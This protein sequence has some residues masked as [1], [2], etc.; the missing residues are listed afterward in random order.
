M[1]YM[2]AVD[3]T[4]SHRFRYGITPRDLPYH[5]S[6]D[7]DEHARDF[8]LQRGILKTSMPCPG[9]TAN[10]SLVAC[11]ASRD[12][13]TTYQY[14]RHRPR[15]ESTDSVGFLGWC[16]T[17]TKNKNLIRCYVR[18]AS[19]TNGTFCTSKNA[20]I[21]GANFEVQTLRGNFLIKTYCQFTIE[22]HSFLHTINISSKKMA[23]SWKMNMQKALKMCS[24]HSAQ[25]KKAK[26]SKCNNIT[27]NPMWTK[28]VLIAHC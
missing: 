14:V 7:T 3:S 28:Q 18:C 1:G 19:H 5:W 16:S 10:M 20:N 24:L 6:T 11:S 26:S 8:L 23:M 13:M 25:P 2:K 9:C 21:W 15:T 22:L 27:T 17:R 4:F 12:I